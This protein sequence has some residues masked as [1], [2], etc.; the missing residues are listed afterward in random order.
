MI[1]V[2][3]LIK[4]RFTNFVLLKIIRILLEKKNGGISL[5]TKDQIRLVYNF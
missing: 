2:Y 1:F 5:Q 3:K 4:I